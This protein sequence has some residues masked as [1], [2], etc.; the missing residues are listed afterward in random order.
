MGD[1]SEFEPLQVHPVDLN[2]DILR[3]ILDLTSDGIWDWN[4]NTGF[5]YRNRG[6]YEMLGYAPHGLANSV[7]TWESLIHPEDFPQV[8]QLFDDHLQQR[9]PRYLAQYRCRMQDGAYTRIEDQGYVVARNA[10]GS[11]AR[12]IGAHRSIEDKQRLVEQLE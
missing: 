5:V 9:S 1:A 11:V 8:M 2:E 4:A 10:D 6:W 12:M 3:A 7:L